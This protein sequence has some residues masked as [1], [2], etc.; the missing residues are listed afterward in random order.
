MSISIRLLDSVATI[1]SNINTAIATLINTRLSQN[2]NRISSLTRGYI[3]SIL[4]A[5]PEIINLSSTSPLSLAGQF[6][7]NISASSISYAIIKS[8]TDSLEVRFVPYNTRLKGAGL[9]I[10]CQPSSFSNLLQLPEGHTVY[11]N[12]DLHWLNWLLTKGDTIIVVNYTYN[13]QTGLGRSGLGNMIPGGSFRV[14]PEYAGNMQDN[15][16]T[17]A[18]SNQQLE[19][20]LTSLIRDILNG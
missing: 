12:G 1:E 20:Q 9:T 4:L 18:L 14:P 10:S 11:M 13:P 15:F 2:I 16:V 7:F 5:S 19:R 3:T 17:R 8:I 6:G